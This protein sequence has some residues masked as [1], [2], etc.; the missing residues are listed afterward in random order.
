MDVS[1]AGFDL[2]LPGPKADPRPSDLFVCFSNVAT[3]I[4]SLLS[5]PCPYSV[6]SGLVEA[7]GNRMPALKLT[8]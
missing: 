4:K 3:F 8:L 5:A 6:Y 2:S 1:E 7:A